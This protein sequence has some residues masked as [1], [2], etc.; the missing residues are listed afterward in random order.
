MSITSNSNVWNNI[1]TDPGNPGEF[2]TGA[3]AVGFAEEI[4]L[5]GGGSLGKR[6]DNGTRVF[7]VGSTQNFDLSGN[8]QH[9]GLF[10]GSITW[11]LVTDVGV[12]SSVI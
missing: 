10:F 11:G 1:D 9:V 5:Q 6:V 3:G 4:Y 7:A 12:A 8:R 2:D